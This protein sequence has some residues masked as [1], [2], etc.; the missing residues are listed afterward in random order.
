M[1][2]HIEGLDRVIRKLGP[3]LIAGPLRKFM[4]RSVLNIEGRWKQNAKANA[5]TG[6]YSNSIGHQVDSAQI[7]RWAKVGTSL[8]YA[9]YDEYGTG[10][11]A[12]GK[13]G[14]GGRH[15]P[16]GDALS[17]WAK[18]HGFESG[19]QV[20]RIIGM[21]GGLK[22]R[23]SMRKAIKAAMGDIRSYVKQ[24]GSDIKDSFG[25]RS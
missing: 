17:V 1:K 7:P 11:F 15:W 18:R 5:D 8:F 4:D 6:K 24:L 16:P 9:P 14:K 21:R 23:R 19:H 22:P 12:E 10:L 25:S 2:V 13:G 20:A 3:Q